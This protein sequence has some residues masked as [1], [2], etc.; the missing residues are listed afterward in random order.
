MKMQMEHTS[1]VSLP[2][3]GCG[4][5]HPSPRGTVCL[6]AC[7]QSPLPCP[8]HSSANGTHLQT[9]HVTTR[10]PHYAK[11]PSIRWARLACRE[12]NE[13]IWFCP[14]PSPRGKVCLLACAQS[15]LPCPSH[16]SANGTHLQTAHITT[17]CPHYAKDPSIRWARLACNE[18][19]EWIRSFDLW[20]IQ[21]N[22]LTFPYNYTGPV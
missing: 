21:F 12:E 16:S 15:R 20:L 9:T 2:S 14:H 19:N 18:E 3:G 11:D 10:C 7:A 4:R 22:L 13:W 5:P 6:L 17:R 1:A 8:C